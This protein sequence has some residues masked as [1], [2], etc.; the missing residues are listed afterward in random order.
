MG[1]LDGLHEISTFGKAVAWTFEGAT[2]GQAEQLLLAT[3]PGKTGPKR[4]VL[5]GTKQFRARQGDS[6]VEV[7]A[8]DPLLQGR[9]YYV[10]TAT[11]ARNNYLSVMS[12]QNDCT[13]Q[14]FE[15]GSED[16]ET[17][18]SSRSVTTPI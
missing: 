12:A 14:V 6:S 15:N 13:I 18:T 11:S 17:G 1:K 8:N 16:P 4:F 2:T 3:D 10:I 7:T 9:V 5:L